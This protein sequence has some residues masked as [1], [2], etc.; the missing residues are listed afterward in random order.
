MPK[1]TNAQLQARIA[2]LEA[3]VDA[4]NAR[5]GAEGTADPL[6]AETGDDRGGRH[7]GR[8]RAAGWAVLS[9]TAVVLASLLP[10]AALVAAWAGSILTDTDRFVATYAPL[11]EDPDVQAFVADETTAAIVDAVDIEGVVSA[12]FDGISGAVGLPPRATE[13]LGLLQGT[14]VDGVV[15]LIDSTVTDIVS[16]DAFAA[17][18]ERALRTAHE[19]LIAT[20]QGDTGALVTIGDDGVLGL[21]IGPIVQQVRATLQEQGVGLA[22]LIPDIDATIVIV[23]SDALPAAKIAYAAT[24][25]SS[26]ALPIVVLVLLAVGVLA[27]R[28]RSAG[29]VGAGIGLAISMGVVAAGLAISASLVGLLIPVSLVPSTVST[30]LFWTVAGGMRDTAIAVLVLAIA[31][32]II[33]WFAGPSRTAVR[34][35]SAVDGALGAARGFGAAH[36][37][38]TGRFG[39]VLRDQRWI[40]RSAIAVV[41]ALV[42]LLVR[43]LDVGLVV[44]TLLVALLVLL[45]VELLR[46][47]DP[48]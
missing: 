16:S 15:G 11:I 46:A 7:H 10:P 33:A 27:A 2:E 37:L 31:V 18:W 17:V 32:A 43:P 23:Q 41:A 3:E 42:L 39:T 44:T 19:Q 12:A 28:R 29:F 22:S 20:M 38:D 5:A 8:R 36:G 9:V 13:A 24:V 21:Q 45:V 1:M 25:G 34:L 4:A 30:L 14:V 40:V 6:E 35:R 48:A 47:P 26:I